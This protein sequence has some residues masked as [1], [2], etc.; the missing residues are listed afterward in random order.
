MGLWKTFI[1]NTTALTDSTIAD[2]D[3]FA[4]VDDSGSVSG[5]ITW[6][7]LKAA[8]AAIHAPLARDIATTDPGSILFFDTF[9][10]ADTAAGVMGTSDSG[11]T[12]TSSNFGIVSNKAQRNSGN[13]GGDY[14]IA[15]V[16]NAN[17]AITATQTV[18]N[19]STTGGRIVARWVDTNNF[20]GLSINSG[21]VVLNKTVS[22]TTTALV[23]CSTADRQDTTGRFTISCDGNVITVL[24]GVGVNIGQY[25]LSGSEITTFGTATIFGIRDNSTTAARRATWDNLVIRRLR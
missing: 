3:E 14:A 16:S 19:V 20:I 7:S 25:T 11:H 22:G 18:P 17:C 15:D 10:R 21:G 1:Q 24:N 23:T 5:R 2:A 9:N 13:V 12:Y 4:M 6:S 8:F